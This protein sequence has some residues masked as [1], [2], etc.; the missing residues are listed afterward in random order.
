MRNTLAEILDPFPLDDFRKEHY[1]RRPLLVLGQPDKF[2]HLFTWA[3][4]THLLNVSPIPHPTMRL[5]LKGDLLEAADAVSVIAQCR[6]GATMIINTIHLFD[7]RVGRFAAQ[8]ATD[9]GE[10]INV[11]MY[12]SQ[13][14]KPAF[15]RHYDIHDVFILQIAGKKGWSVYD[16]TVDY[17]LFEM[18]FHGA[19]PPTEPRIQCVLSP[20]DVLYIPRGHWHEATAA[21]EQSLHLT[22]GIDAHTGIDFLTWMVNELREDTRCRTLLPL[23]FHD[24]ESTADARE[25]RGAFLDGVFDRLED[26][27]R[28]PETMSAYFKYRTASDRGVNRFSLPDQL[29]KA[30][31]NHLG[32]TRFVRP[33]YQ[34][35]IIEYD[36]EASELVVTVWGRVIRLPVTAEALVRLILSRDRFDFDECHSVVPD[37]SVD[38]TW[39]I[40]NAFVREAIIFDADRE[41]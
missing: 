30:P 16:Q 12:L 31:A 39:M 21:D 5:S 33:T 41:R 26:K 20:G 11:N 10:P 36:D 22:V 40:V 6:A 7:E 29:L 14:S 4:L 19:T 37:L 28:S 17:P 8:L 15:N 35:A 38:E 1:A 3:D 13:P 2:G 34:R 18:K 24:E 27:F 25:A 9:V 23:V 32:V